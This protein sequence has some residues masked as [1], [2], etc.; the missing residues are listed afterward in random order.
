M[1]MGSANEVDYQ[2]LLAKDLDYIENNQHIA[3]NDKVDK[4]KR[5]LANLI[6]KVRANS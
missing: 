6:T 3:L 1:A 2:L 4:I 5:Q